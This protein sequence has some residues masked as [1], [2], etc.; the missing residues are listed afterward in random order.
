[1]LF[2][3]TV[4]VLNYCSWCHT[5]Q[6]G[7]LLVT[8]WFPHVFALPFG[9]L[10]LPA[11]A[12]LQFA[13]CGSQ[14]Q[15]PVGLLPLVPPYPFHGTLLQFGLVH[16]FTVAPRTPTVYTFAFTR[17]FGY[18]RLRLLRLCVVVGC[19]DLRVAFAV[20]LFP[21]V[22]SHGLRTTPFTRLHLRL[23]WFYVLVLFS[24]RVARCSL[25]LPLPPRSG[26]CSLRLVVTFVCCT[27]TRA[28]IF[29]P[30]FTFPFALD[31]PPVDSGSGSPFG[32]P[33]TAA[34]RGSLRHI[35]PAALRWH[36]MLFSPCA[37]K[38]AVV[39]PHICTHM[40]V[41]VGC[42]KHF[43]TTTAH[44]C[45][46]HW[47]A[48]YLRLQFTSPYAAWFAF[49]FVPFV[50][51][52]VTRFVAFT[53][54]CVSHCVCVCRLL[55]VLTFTVPRRLVTVLQ[56]GWLRVYVLVARLRLLPLLPTWFAT[57]F[58][59]FTVLRTCKHFFNGSH[60]SLPSPHM[61]YRYRLF[62]TVWFAPH[63]S[64]SATHAHGYRL[65]FWLVYAFGLVPFSIFTLHTPRLFVV[66]RCV[67][68]LF[69]CVWFCCVAFY[70][71]TFCLRLRCVCLLLRSAFV[72]STFVCLRFVP[73]H[74]SF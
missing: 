41:M 27:V 34:L 19:V 51:T 17:L 21:F 33:L 32:S 47:L 69:V 12:F 56:F 53:R 22:C 64:R 55:R 73:V 67:C 7:F 13:R 31:S 18:V 48:G 59:R 26:G 9:S 72:C 60:G 4:V 65:P 46:Y 44:R 14:F 3:V 38:H 15:F 62:H 50:V 20:R 74:V 16:A 23:R 35:S 71:V 40:V 58:S 6:F 28:L 52:L 8:V 2:V 5:T 43:T 66:L 49:A 30:R 54:V 10:V 11:L 57:T 1:V 29:L 25:R 37:I 70:F 45:L 63:S 42:L 61:V 24:L 39:H 68:S 36:N